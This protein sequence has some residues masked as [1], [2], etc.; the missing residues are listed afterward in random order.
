VSR[1]VAVV[2]LLYTP[3]LYAQGGPPISISYDFYPYNHLSNPAAG[4]AEEDLEIQVATL[5]VNLSAPP[6]VYSEGRTVISNS[7]LYQSFDLDWKNWENLME[8]E[9]KIEHTYAIEYT[10]NVTHV[11]SEKWSLMAMLIPGLATDFK[12]ELSRYDFTYQTVLVFIRKHSDR[13]S[14][15]YGLAYN[16][17][18]GMPFPV[19]VFACE[20]NNGRNMRFSAIVPV[21][22]E[23]WYAPHPKVH[24][25]ALFKIAGN[26]YHGDPDIFDVDVPF[27]RYSIGTIGPALKFLPTPWLHLGVEAGYTFIRRFEYFDDKEEAASYDLNNTGFLKFTVVI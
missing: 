17:Q 22:I 21:G 5:N 9:H 27:L 12:P 11:L 1:A 2:L 8:A 24:L 4:T 13:L 20:W 23:Y 25:G 14:L 10:L 6:L 7:I 15:G 3:C 26:Q 16:N 18:F 19:P